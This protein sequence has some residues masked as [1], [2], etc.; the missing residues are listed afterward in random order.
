MQVKLSEEFEQGMSLSHS[1]VVN[2][3]DLLDQDVLSLESSEPADIALLTSSQE[4][5]D[6]AEV[7]ED[8]ICEPS[9][10][11]RLPFEELLEV[12]A[13]FAERLDLAWWRARWEIT[14]DSCPSCSDFPFLPDLYAEVERS[15]EKTF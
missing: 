8:V 12:M 4:E 7:G 9:Q 14:S 13:S 1:S 10:P 15:W 6:E 2:S 3:S 5:L 11:A